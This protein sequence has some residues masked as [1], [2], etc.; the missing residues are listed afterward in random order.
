M[1]ET[2][3][4][5]ERL[6]SKKVIA[7]LFDNGDSFVEYP[8][9]VVWVLTPLDSKFP[10]QLAISVSKKNFKSAVDRNHIKRQ[11]REIYRKN[12]SIHYSAFTKV[13]TQ[14]AMMIIYTEK[15]KVEFEKMEDGLVKLLTRLSEKIVSSPQDTETDV[16]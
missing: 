5:E 10:V 7:S 16:P 9:R 14:C 15:E 6:K 3:K 1:N 4:R 13:N 8:Y 2:F 12:K 11:I